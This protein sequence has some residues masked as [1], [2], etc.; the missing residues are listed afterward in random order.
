MTRLRY[1]NVLTTILNRYILKKPI[2]H[3][4]SCVHFSFIVLYS[5]ISFF[6]TLVLLIMHNLILLYPSL[7]I[8]TLI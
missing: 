3:I 6:Y 4:I 2:N 8:Y 1:G 7:I 5:L